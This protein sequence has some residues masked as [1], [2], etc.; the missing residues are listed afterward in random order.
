MSE[1]R[2]TTLSG[3]L[4]QSGAHY[5]VFDMGRRICRLD[6][7]TFLGF[8]RAERPYPYPFQ[9]H[10]LLAVLFWHPEHAQ[11]RHY[12][13]FLKFPLD[14]QGLLDQAARDAFVLALLER[15]GESMLANAGE[16]DIEG[17]MKDSPYVFTPREDRMAAF[18]AHA[19]RSLKLP[20]SRYYDDAYQY[21]T[22]KR[23]LHDWQD[24]GMQ[25]VADVA[26]RL[27]DNEET[28]GLIE[29]LPYLPDEPFNVLSTF[30]EHAE[31]A[32]G[33]V[34]VLSQRVNVELQEKQPDI[35]RICSCLR[36][37]SNSPARGLVDEMARRVLKHRCSSDVEVLAVIC[38][39]L[40]RVLQDASMCRLFVE[41]LAH[42]PDGYAV[43]SQLLADVMFMPGLRDPLMQALRNPQRSERLARYVG[44][45]FSAE[46]DS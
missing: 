38:G 10:A 25:G 8:E 29:T 30:L 19:R 3:F 32:A 37:A 7:A 18:N 44:R 1:Q 6:A 24:L 26:V 43:F 39:R 46:K 4:H 27:D 28:L 13:W 5:S 31:P 12:V 15:I 36:A 35:A 42:N 14:E 17:M 34:E 21:F 9:R 20:P 11:D 2:I 22:G 40:W 16:T 33:I 41:Q 23:D 45:L